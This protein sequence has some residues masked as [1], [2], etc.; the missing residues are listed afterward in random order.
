MGRRRQH[1]VDDVVMVA[2]RVYMTIIDYDTEASAYNYLCV[3]TDAQGRHPRGPVFRLQP[4]DMIAATGY[5][6][7]RPGRIHRR[8]LR[9]NGPPEVSGCPCG[10]C[11][12]VAGMEPEPDE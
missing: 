3:E 6:S 12:H 10:C 1:E 11:V 7:R 5:K 4:K 2:R 9:E 8:Q